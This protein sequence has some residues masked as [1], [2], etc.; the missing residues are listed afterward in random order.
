[1]VLTYT[2]TTMSCIYTH[3]LSESLI[4]SNHA[5]HM[6]MSINYCDYSKCYIATNFDQHTVIISILY[7]GIFL[8][9]GILTLINVLCYYKMITQ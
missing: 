8:T 5:S 9:F 6:Q 3:L 7:Y 1:M 4:E 2:E